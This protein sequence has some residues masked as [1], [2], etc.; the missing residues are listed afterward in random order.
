VAIAC[1]DGFLYSLTLDGKIRWKLQVNPPH[2]P[3]LS[4]AKGTLY[5]SGGNALRAIGTGGAVLWAQE[6]LGQC[7]GMALS[8]DGTLYV[9]I[10]NYLYALHD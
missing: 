2:A 3:P 4:D 7:T 8:D 10:R 1:D 9:Q 6:G 5:V